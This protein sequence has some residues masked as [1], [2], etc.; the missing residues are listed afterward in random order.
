MSQPQ[1]QQWNSNELAPQH[2][3]AKVMKKLFKE[4]SVSRVAKK[5]GLKQAVA[6][7]AMHS[8][9]LLHFDM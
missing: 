5:N 7:S 9:S 6:S 1:V 4:T 8:T 3:H 2:K